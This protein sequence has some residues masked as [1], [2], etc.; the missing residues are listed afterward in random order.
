MGVG[1]GQREQPRVQISTFAS[2][3]ADAASDRQFFQGEP[4]VRVKLGQRSLSVRFMPGD[5]DAPERMALVDIGQST[6]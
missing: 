1:S 5:D 3:S 6:V 4:V 2:K